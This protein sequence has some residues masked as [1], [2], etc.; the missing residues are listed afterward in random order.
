MLVKDT[1]TF[2]ADLSSEGISGLVGLGPSSGSV[3]LGA[4]G[5]S[6]GNT[7]LDNIFLQNTST[8][9]FIS[10]LLQRDGDPT[11]SFSGELTVGE[12][13]AP[14]DNIT[15]QPKLPVQVL[16]SSS[17]SAQHWTTTLDEDGIIG[18]DGQPIKISSIVPDN[19]GKLFAVIDSG[20]TLPQVPRKVSDAIYG[21]VQGAN[22]SV[23][24]S[25]WTIPCGQELNI[26][27]KLGGVTF[28]VHPL[29]TSS[30]D[31]AMTNSKGETV[32]VGTVR[33]IFAKISP[34]Y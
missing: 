1:S 11:Q 34:L 20:F 22:Y 18:P 10:F 3:I 30:S 19:G 6:T 9:N 16:D 5:N 15:S 21:R 14:F 17:R 33:N 32:C 25:V 27:F 31:F 28:P 13:I 26:S 7:V 8:P 24:N 23:E 2:T 12:I 29:D 4:L